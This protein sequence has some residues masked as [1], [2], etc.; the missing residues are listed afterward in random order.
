MN[1]GEAVAALRAGKKVRHAGWR[2]D[3]RYPSFLVLIPGRDITASYKPMTD[4]LGEG[5][6]FHVDDHID[7]IFDA[8]TPQMSCVVGRAFPQDELLS[9]DWVVVD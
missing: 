8:G 1:I 7:A 6:A 5:A 4:H 3:L 2:D 9:D